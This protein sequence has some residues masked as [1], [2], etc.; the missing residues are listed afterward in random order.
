M[1]IPTDLVILRLI[2]KLYY[3]EFK[4]FS[5]GGDVD[6]GRKTKIFVPIDCSLIADELNVD[7]DIVFGRLYY[8]MQERYGYTRDDG[9]KVAFYASIAGESNRCINFSYARISARGIRGGE[10]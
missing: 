3:E 1:K 10:Q 4:N 9:S 7:A 5:K 2:Y 8:Y 6:N